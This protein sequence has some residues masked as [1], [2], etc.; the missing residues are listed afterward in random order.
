M[1]LITWKI[2]YLCR[3]NSLNYSCK[4]TILSQ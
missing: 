4:E 2:I 1:S 3:N